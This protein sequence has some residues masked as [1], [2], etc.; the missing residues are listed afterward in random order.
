MSNQNE[1]KYWIGDTLPNRMVITDIRKD[2]NI[3]YDLS[4]NDEIIT[5][6]E[7]YIDNIMNEY[8]QKRNKSIL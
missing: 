5:V 4:L 1:A 3:V 6:E 8:Y 2:D 7:A